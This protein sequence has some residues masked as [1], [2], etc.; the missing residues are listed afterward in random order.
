MCPYFLL[1][2]QSKTHK[3][4]TF[5]RESNLKYKKKQNKRE[6][7]GNEETKS[8]EEEKEEKE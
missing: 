4:A 6:N 7:Q 1:S 2:I 8:R 3:I 5:S